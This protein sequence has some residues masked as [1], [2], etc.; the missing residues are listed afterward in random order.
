M[1]GN[2]D[3]I[4][5]L[6]DAYNTQ[7]LDVLDEVLASDLVSHTPGSDMLPPGIEGIKAGHQMSMTGFPDKHEEILDIFEEGD[8]VVSHCRMTGTNTGGLPWFGVE[9]NDK[10]VDVRWIQISRFEDGRVKET[11]AQMD[12]PTMMVQLGAMP[13]PGA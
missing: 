1:G 6:A 8:L 11:W 13:A 5:R 4:K 9:A 2:I 12:L 3:A 10:P 7:N